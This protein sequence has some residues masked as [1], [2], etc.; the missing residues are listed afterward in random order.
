MIQTLQLESF[1][2]VA[3]APPPA[4]VFDEADLA[5]A[6]AAG[7]VEG[8]AEGRDAA[9][10]ILAAA[11]DELA[12]QLAAQD[13]RLADSSRHLEV[14]ISDVARAIIAA[15]AA[16]LRAETLSAQVC[17]ALAAEIEAGI[18]APP[19]LRCEAASAPALRAALDSGGLHQ[20]QIDTGG[21]GAEFGVPDGLVRLDPDRLQAALL[22]IVAEMDAPDP[23]RPADTS[24]PEENSDE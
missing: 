6:R 22:A 9:A 7:R 10:S 3:P 18:P 4:A 2:R 19:R 21:S 5:M 16:P 11:V 1:L 17:A 20:I 12:A 24:P 15:L 13:R 14:Q 8:L 23:G